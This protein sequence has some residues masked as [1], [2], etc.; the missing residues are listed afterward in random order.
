MRE[1]TRSVRRVE[2]FQVEAIGAADTGHCGAAAAPT[3]A[4]NVPLLDQAELAS[5]AREQPGRIWKLDRWHSEQ[6]DD[7][8]LYAATDVDPSRPCAGQ[9]V[10]CSSVPNARVPVEPFVSGTPVA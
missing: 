1:S 2:I 6:F 4:H 3:E 8:N 9:I 7:A 10:P 5:R